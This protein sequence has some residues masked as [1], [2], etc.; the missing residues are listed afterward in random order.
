MDTGII[1][2]AGWINLTTLLL[3]RFASLDRAALHASVTRKAA[4]YGF[5]PRWVS[6]HPGG[7]E[8][9]AADPPPFQ[10]VV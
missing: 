2:V 3:W 1:S 4:Y 7:T 6:I 10:Q 9:A 8:V 5:D